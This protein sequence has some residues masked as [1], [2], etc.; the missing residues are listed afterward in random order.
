M[1]MVDIQ[2]A[3][4]FHDPGCIEILFIEFNHVPLT[5]EPGFCPGVITSDMIPGHDTY[6][7]CRNTNAAQ[8]TY[9]E[10]ALSCAGNLFLRQ[11]FKRIHI[12]L[13]AL[14]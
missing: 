11:R 5:I 6:G 10:N 2:H 8:G 14:R 7:T 13:A 12:V 4:I 3:D 9:Q 1:R